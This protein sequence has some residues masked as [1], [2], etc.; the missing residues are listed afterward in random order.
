MRV[1]GPYHHVFQASGW[2]WY[3]RGALTG[4]RDHERGPC[5]CVPPATAPS[6][7]RRHVPHRSKPLGQRRGAVG[8]GLGAPGPGQG[9][10]DRLVIWTNAPGDRL[11]RWPLRGCRG[12]QPWRQC[13]PMA[14]GEEGV[15]AGLA[16]GAPAHSGIDL[17][18]VIQDAPF[19]LSHMTGRRQQEPCEVR[20]CEGGGV[21]RLACTPRPHGPPDPT[22]RA[23][24]SPRHELVIEPTGIVTALRPARPRGIPGRG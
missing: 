15:S 11:A 3:R 19:R 6:Q 20:A 14:R 22:R 17:Q 21:G 13:W 9:G 18:E 1:A 10:G 8:H 4:R 24:T 5:R 23:L 2:P 16:R 12:L 7:R